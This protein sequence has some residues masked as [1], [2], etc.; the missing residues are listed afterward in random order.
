[1]SLKQ[2][3]TLFEA[4]HIYRDLMESTALQETDHQ[5]SVKRLDFHHIRCR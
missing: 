3:E 1:M 2:E 4:N 5:K